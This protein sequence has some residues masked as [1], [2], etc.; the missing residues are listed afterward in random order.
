MRLFCSAFLSF[1]LC[2]SSDSRCSLSP[3]S[4]NRP[5]QA[6]DFIR[7]NR[8]CALLLTPKADAG[9]RKE[10]EK[11]RKV[12]K[13]E[14]SPR[15]RKF[16]TRGGSCCIARNVKHLPSEIIFPSCGYVPI[17][18]KFRFHENYMRD[19]ELVLFGGKFQ[20]SSPSPA[21]LVRLL[22]AGG[23]RFPK[24]QPELLVTQWT[25]I[26]RYQPSDREAV[27]SVFREGIEEHILP[28]FTFAMSRGLHVS[29]SVLIFSVVYVT[30]GG[31]VSLGLVC[32]GAW[33]GLV[34]FCCFEFYAGYVRARLSTDMKDICEYYL[35]NPDNCFWVAEGHGRILGM[36]A[37][38]GK[39]AEGG[40][41]KMYGEIYRMIVSSS[42]RRTGL[43]VRLGTVAEDFCRERGFS[44]I[45]LSTSSTQ[46]A[47]VSLYLKLGFK[48]IRVHTE[49][50]KAKF[51]IW[52]TRA[53]ILTMEKHV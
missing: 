48:L 10:E 39:K 20:R 18:Q 45:E 2:S 11:R 13:P 21:L 41:G 22:S 23:Q 6:L 36:V 1:A 32:A 40:D 9:E 50:E 25:V 27:E 4:Q 7:T 42:A 30:S 33:V 49:S 44:K 19:K 12:I 52:M 26:R 46:R 3:E 34:Y 29:V 53:T 28:A 35:S 24:I 51:V 15:S 17:S 43:G 16:L 8:W 14:L 31:S 38:E 37:V 47:A 5:L